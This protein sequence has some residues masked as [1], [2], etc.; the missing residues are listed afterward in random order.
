MPTGFDALTPLQQTFLTKYFGVK[1][2]GATAH[3]KALPVWMVAREAADRDIDA[4]QN[5]LRAQKAPIF[6]KIADAGLHGITS[7]EMTRMQAALMEFDHA[8]PDDKAKAAART[9]AAMA[10]MRA[11]LDGNP[12]LGLLE[13][14]PFGLAR[15]RASGIGR[16]ALRV[17]FRVTRSRTRNRVPL[18][19]LA[20]G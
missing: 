1:G 2:S 10:Q 9:Q 11:F 7:G 8:G 19:L 12:V 13:R 4:L 20:S 16:A 5:L 18:P 6:A 17:S 3:D 14:N 15:F